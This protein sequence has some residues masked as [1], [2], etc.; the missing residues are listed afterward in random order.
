MPEDDVVLSSNG[1]TPETSTFSVCPPSLRDRF[2]VT[3]W[4]TVTSRFRT[5]VGTKPVLKTVTVYVPASSPNTLYVPSLSLLALRSIPMPLLRT[6]ISA[7]A[8]GSPCW[9]ATIPSV[10]DVV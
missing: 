6:C 8:T 5:V 1:A 3:V 4:L 7:P 10:V 2:R 9:S